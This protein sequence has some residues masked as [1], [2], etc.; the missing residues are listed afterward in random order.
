MVNIDI[1]FKFH[2]KQRNEVCMLRN[3][4]THPRFHNLEELLNDAAPFGI[5]ACEILQREEAANAANQQLYRTV[6]SRVSTCQTELFWEHARP[7]YKPAIV[8]P[9]QLQSSSYKYIT[10]TGASFA[11]C[12]QQ[13]NQITNDFWSAQK[14]CA[15]LYAQVW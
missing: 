10:T 9:N 8:A 4:T 6:Q 2:T 14:R 7:Q 13:C 1:I 11:L 12:L 3:A 5:R 15:A